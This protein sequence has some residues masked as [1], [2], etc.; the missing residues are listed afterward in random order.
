[1]LFPIALFVIVAIFQTA[2]W[3]HAGAVA[4]AAADHGAEVAAS[5]GSDDAAGAAAAVDL[6][7]KAGVIGNVVVQSA[8]PPASELVT[9]TVS[10]TYPS[11]IGQRDVRATATTVR[12]RAGP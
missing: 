10:G 4:Q 8:N 2:L 5:F 1:M 7:S 11:L 6:A 12:E 9:V 3:A